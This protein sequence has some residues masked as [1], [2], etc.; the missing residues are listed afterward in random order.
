M[1]RMAKSRQFSVFEN[2]SG[3]DSF[4]DNPCSNRESSQRQQEHRI[5][6]PGVFVASDDDSSFAFVLADV[7]KSRNPEEKLQAE[8]SR[9]RHSR[10]TLS[11]PSTNYTSEPSSNYPNNF[12]S[13]YST[14]LCFENASSSQIQNRSA[15]EFRPSQ[16]KLVAQEAHHSNLMHNRAKRDNL[17][18]LGSPPNSPLSNTNSG[19]KSDPQ[20]FQY[21]I[22]GEYI[23]LLLCLGYWPLIL[24][25]YCTVLKI[26]LSN[27]FLYKNSQICWLSLY[28]KPRG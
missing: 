12:P 10:L 7:A 6:S 28:L 25:C 21:N 14:E 18:D 11:A 23:L 17:I 2:T 26:L 9:S 20:A 16:H 24:T 15:A 1:I 3:R 19:I 13:K 22:P 4:C 5:A 8:L 27:V